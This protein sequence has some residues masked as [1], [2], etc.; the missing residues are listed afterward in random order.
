M[1]TTDLPIII[2][3]DFKTNIET[4]WK[5]LTEL[6]QMQQWYFNQLVDFK[7]E[8]GFETEFALMHEGR[9]FTHIWKITEVI[10]L[11]K[12][13]YVWKFKEY[14]GSSTVTFSLKETTKGTQLHFKDIVLESFPKDIP[15]FKRESGLAGWNYLIGESLQKYLEDT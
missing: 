6:K 5:A 13:S 7:A 1:Q 4:V 12:I 11:E 15:E 14:P 9:T 10:P 2:E 8:V 3:A